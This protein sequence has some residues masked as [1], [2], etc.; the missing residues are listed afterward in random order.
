MHNALKVHNELHTQYRKG[1]Y[2]IQSERNTGPN[3]H[4]TIYISLVECVG[5]HGG[6]NIPDP[7]GVVR[8]TGDEGALGYNS[9]H[10]FTL[11]WVSLHAPNTRRMV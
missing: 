7:Y 1:L 4:T 11:S 3:T 10:T 6:V 9:L 2:D 5:F 8:G